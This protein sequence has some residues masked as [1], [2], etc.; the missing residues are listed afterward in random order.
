MARDEATRVRQMPGDYARMLSVGVLFSYVLVVVAALLLRT[1]VLTSNVLS[2]PVLFTTSLLAALICLAAWRS[3]PRDVNVPWL[4]FGCAGLAASFSHVAVLLGDSVMLRAL[5]HLSWA[6]SYALFV[7]GIVVSIQQSERGR[8]PEL[9]MDAALVIVAATVMMLRWSPGIQQVLDS[10][11]FP[12]GL[13]AIFAPVMSFCAALFM[14]VL[15]ASPPASL[16]KSTGY[17]LAMAGVGLIISTLPQ[18]ITGSPCCHDNSP[19]TLAAAGMWVFLT[20]AGATALRAGGRGVVVPQGERLRQYVA[21]TVAVIL[22]AISIDTSLHPTAERRTAIAI[23]VLA[24]LLALRLT[25][26]LHATRS[27]VAERRELAQ[28]RALME[29]SRALSGA[30]DLDDTL[31]T[32][33][34]W[35]QRVFN[36]KGAS[37]E[38]LAPGSKELELRTVA[39]LP[40][41]IIGSKYPLDRSFTGWVVR[42]GDVRVS[43]NAAQD[44]MVGEETSALLGDAP[45]AS[46]PLRYR[47]RILGVLSCVGT[48][49]FDASDLELLRAFASQASIA[50]EDARLFEQVRTLSVTDPL[51][52]LANRRHLD[53][54]LEREFAAARRGRRLVAVMFDLD[55]FKE[56]N[57]RY[58]H[59]AGDRALK[60]FADALNATMRA[61]NLGARFGGDEFFALLADSDPAGAQVFVERV[62]ERFH[63]IM[64]ETGNPTLGVSAGI[65]EFKADMN[66]P[67]E[68]IEAADRALYISKSAAGS[69]K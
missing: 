27:Q 36:A 32:V 52:G 53:R 51:T 16:P 6:A 47:E 43:V 69:S 40:Q 29:V 56:H 26:L 19:A 9:G 4:L 12:S 30:N 54:E 14:V 65:A 13:L 1:N 28:T 44:P 15:L 17:A 45:L 48:R 23:G 49:P 20:V 67:A 41:D 50:I 42:N 62:T 18:V 5:I 57:D 66:T 37:I 33:T 63:S 8:W 34:V 24:V 10:S 46:V 22:A 2:G 7:A 59:L 68:L 64:R 58:G 39:G 35:A 21:P 55:E 3:L 38:L 61:M 31:R 25:Q 11:S 60:H